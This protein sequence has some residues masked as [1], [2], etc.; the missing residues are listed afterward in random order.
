MLLKRTLTT[1]VALPVLIAAVWFQQPVPW[2]TIF[3]LIWSAV[4][5]WEFYRLNLKAGLKPMVYFGIVLSILLVAVR[6]PKFISVFNTSSESLSLALLTAAIIIP[7]ILLLS[8]EPR[9]EAFTS[10]VWT[11][12]GISYV[13]FLLG[14]LIALRGLENGRNWVFFALL[15]TFA[16]DTA[17]FFI[18]RALGR[19]KLAPAISP[20]KTW[21]GS[22][23]GLLG[24]GL[25]SL[26]FLPAAFSSW[27]NPLYLPSLN[28]WS[29]IGLALLISIFGQLGDLVESLFKRNMGAKDSGNIL[30]GHG[31][32]LDRMDSVAFSGVMVYYF[33]WLIL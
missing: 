16:S 2:F 25:I 28:V 1:L 33:V 17:A 5:A 26:I 29:A 7:L 12:A 3:I 11:F 9:N 21:E 20:S 15:I 13:G 30:P 8:R 10:W 22:V 4:A 24:A 32:A 19:H 18:G 27:N 6:E 23:G 31:G 14:H